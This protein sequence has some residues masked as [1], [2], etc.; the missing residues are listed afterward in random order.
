MMDNEFSLPVPMIL[1][2]DQVAPRTS[3]VVPS[4]AFVPETYR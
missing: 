1:F 4:S 2:Q 3:Q